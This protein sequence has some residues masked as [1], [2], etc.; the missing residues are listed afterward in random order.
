M[1]HTQL[2]KYITLLFDSIGNE[3]EPYLVPKNILRKANK[4]I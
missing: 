2:Y 4:S 1:I 3:L